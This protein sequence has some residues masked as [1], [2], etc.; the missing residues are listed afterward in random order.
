MECLAND[1]VVG[2]LGQGTH[3]ALVEGGE[4]ILHE[5]D[6]PVLRRRGPCRGP[7]SSRSGCARS[8]YISNRTASQNER[9]STPAPR[10]RQGQTASPAV[11]GESWG[12]HPLRAHGPQGRAQKPVPWMCARVTDQ[13]ARPRNW[14]WK[15]E[16]RNWQCGGTRDAR[17]ASWATLSRLSSILLP[18]AETTASV[19]PS[20]AGALLTLQPSVHPALHRL[21][22]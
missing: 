18:W 22:T 9:G 5:A 10:R 11:T 1:G 8:A 3:A 7:A 12:C 20:T 21:E 13:T 4:V 14:N 15:M 2:L 16:L 19:S 6:D 17:P